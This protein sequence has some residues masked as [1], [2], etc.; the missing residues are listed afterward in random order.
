MARPIQHS[1]YD[2][3]EVIGLLLEWSK[4]DHPRKHLSRSSKPSTYGV[5]WNRKLSS[6]WWP[7]G[8]M[9][10]SNPRSFQQGKITSKVNLFRS[11]LSLVWT[12]QGATLYCF[13]D[14]P[15]WMGL[16]QEVWGHFM[17]GPKQPSDQD[18]HVTQCLQPRCH[19]KVHQWGRN[20]RSPSTLGTQ[21]PRIQSIIV[22][23][24]LHSLSKTEVGL[25]S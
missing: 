11:I 1:Y 16:W 13:P 22:G 12:G 6:R 21:S 2:L 9:A 24:T 14:V 8:P 18:L 7:P 19:K 17:T 20:S 4:M 23:E 5:T 15:F 3:I 25:R 10:G